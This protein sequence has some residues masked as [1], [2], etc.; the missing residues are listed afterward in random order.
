LYAR[1]CRR[2]CCQNRR[3]SKRW[4]GVSC[5]P[6]AGCSH[7]PPGCL[8]ENCSAPCETNPRAAQEPAPAWTPGGSAWSEIR[9]ALPPAK[10]WEPAA[11][12]RLDQ[13]VTEFLVVLVAGHN[14]SGA[15][16]SM[17]EKGIA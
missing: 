2:C 8:R 11:C 15:E 3:K 14:R 6:W 12:H 13:V 17:T 10:P 5:H 16:R 4:Q 9:A 7:K 1:P